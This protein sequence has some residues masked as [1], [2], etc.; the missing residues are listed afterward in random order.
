MKITY[1]DSEALAKKFGMSRRDFHRK[2]KTYIVSDFKK[3]L[4]EKNISNPDIGLDSQN[5]IYLS[6]TDHSEVIPT[7]LN[8]TDYI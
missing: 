2:I 7:D 1:Y 5:N 6:D 4:D 8:V 3:E